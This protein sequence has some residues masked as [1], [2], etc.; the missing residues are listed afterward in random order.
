MCKYN[1]FRFILQIMPRICFK[2]I[3]IFAEWEKCAIFARRKIRNGGYPASYVRKLALLEMK[4][5][6]INFKT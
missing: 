3:N 5:F 6:I 1:T 4:I 2:N